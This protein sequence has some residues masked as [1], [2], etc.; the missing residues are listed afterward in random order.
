M[1][2]TR[3]L[4]TVLTLTAVALCVTGCAPKPQPV[5]PTTNA[6]GPTTP[7]ATT[8]GPMEEYVLIGISTGVEYWNA[9]DQGGKDATAELGVE[10]TFAGPPDQ[11][12]ERQANDM[13]SI[14]ARKPAGILI[15]PGDPKMLIPYINKAMDQ[16]IPVICIDTDAP[17]SKRIA[18]F[19]TENYNAGVIGAKT[20]AELIGGKGK[21]CISTRPGQWNLDERLRGYR[22][23]F[24]KDY[25]GITIVQVIDD[26]TK[27]A[28][29]QQ[30]AGAVLNQHPDLAGFAGCNAA[31]G[32]GVARAVKDAGKVGKVKVVAM[33][34]DK[35]IL[36]LIDEG[37][38]QAS[39]AQRQYR[40]AYI[41]VRYLYGLN[42]GKYRA[43]GDTTK[44]DLPEIPKVIDTGTKVVTKDNV[45][46][47]RTPSQGCKEEMKPEE[48]AI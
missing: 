27:Y 36:D 46:Q 47:F 1:S 38:I 19:G 37:V 48:L 41:G 12:P 14:I 11:N 35:A 20:L 22:K 39:V 43:P 5:T 8:G 25:P 44:P 6:P 23:T 15:A 40:M 33:D 28:V 9:T 30:R 2:L 26:E 24:E 13:D 10:W 17:E 32:P 31:S 45:A 3:L 7:T 4:V 21:V 34:A 18:Y 42:H 16:G 29:G